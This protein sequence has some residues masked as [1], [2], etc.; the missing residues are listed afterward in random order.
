MLKNVVRTTEERVD[1]LHCAKKVL[2]SAYFVSPLKELRRWFYISLLSYMQLDSQILYMKMG[3]HHSLRNY[4]FK[5][6]KPSRTFNY[7]LRRVTLTVR[8]FL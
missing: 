1:S 7:S 4:K 6:L 2:V 8:R 5:L 3:E